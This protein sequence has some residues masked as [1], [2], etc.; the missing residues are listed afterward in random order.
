MALGGVTEGP[1]P[2]TRSMR[3]EETLDTFEI[4]V[5]IPKPEAHI[6]VGK[7]STRYELDPPEKSFLKEIERSVD[8]K[9]L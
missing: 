2:T 1:K 9:S 6:M 4:V 7:M 3:D 5:R 8:N